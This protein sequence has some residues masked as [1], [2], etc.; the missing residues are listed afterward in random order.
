M[1]PIVNQIVSLNLLGSTIEGKLYGDNK[2]WSFSS[3]D[4][5]FLRLFPTGIAYSFSQY[6]RGPELARAKVFQDMLWHK[7]DELLAQH[8]G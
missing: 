4:P 7:M 2:V 3:S 8:T 5:A 1:L 6:G